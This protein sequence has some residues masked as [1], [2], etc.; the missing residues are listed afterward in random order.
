[1]AKQ[2]FKAGQ[3]G[4]FPLRPFC[5][6][7]IILGLVLIGLVFSS[8][9]RIL[10]HGV[11]ARDAPT[12]VEAWLARELRHIA[13]PSPDRRRANPVAFSTDAVAAGMAHWADH[14]AICHGND[15]KGSTEMGMHMYPRAPNMTQSGTQRLSDGELFAIIK[16][17][18]RLTGM[19]AWGSPSGETDVQTWQLVRFIR[20]LPGL[21]PE[22][23]NQMKRMNPAS[24]MELEQQQKENEFLNGGDA[25]D[26]VPSNPISHSDR[27][28]KP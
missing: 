10:Q 19:P 20:H 15:G 3:G 7:V 2:N 23:L 12:S 14:C 24:P 18:V 9:A 13:V 8:L 27:K 25:S 28:G 16:N 22:D 4:R 17:G 6:A 26:T 11:S 5:T 1:M 21:T